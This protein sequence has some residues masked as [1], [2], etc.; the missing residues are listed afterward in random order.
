MGCRQAGSASCF[1]KGGCILGALH[2]GEEICGHSNKGDFWMNL[3]F[4]FLLPS[5]NFCTLA[6]PTHLAG[7]RA[8]RRV[9]VRAWRRQWSSC[10]LKW[11]PCA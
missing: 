5:S 9:A 1:E 2:L 10:R 11:P 4:W 8:T 3:A 6:S 7:T